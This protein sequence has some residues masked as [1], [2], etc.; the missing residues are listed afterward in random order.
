MQSKPPTGDARLH[1]TRIDG[2]RPYLI[3]RAVDLFDWRTDMIT[4]G[5]AVAT[6]ALLLAVKQGKR[7]ALA[8][9]RARAR[10]S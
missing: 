4:I 8:A 2:W 10:R 5:A 3:W 1:E 6:A 9:S 7:T